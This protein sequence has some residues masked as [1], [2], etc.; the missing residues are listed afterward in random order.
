MIGGDNQRYMFSWI[1]VS[2]SRVIQ[3]EIVFDVSFGKEQF[4]DK[5]EEYEV[6][7]G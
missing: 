5:R 3:K 6:C 7:K 2:M 1:M 4:L